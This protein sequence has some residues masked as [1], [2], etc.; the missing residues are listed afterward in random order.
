MTNDFEWDHEVDVLIVGAGAAG[1]AGALAGASKGLD[2][3]LIEKTDRYGGTTA[4]SGGGMWIP[5][6][7]VLERENAGDTV[8]DARTYFDECLALNHDDVPV[9][10][11]QAFL[12][13]GPKAIAF[14]EGCSKHIKFEWVKGYPDYHPELPGGRPLGRQIQASAFDAG[15]LG[16]E[17]ANLRPTLRLVPMPFGMWIMIQEGRH[18]SM[19]GVS[20]RSR[21]LSIRLGLRGLLAKLRGKKIMASGGHMLIA[22]LRAAMI[23]AQI[24]LWL[25]T[26]LEEL[27]T[28]DAGDVVGA[29]VKRDGEP[30]RVRVRG[31][32][33][34]TTGGFERNAEMRAEFQASPIGTKW[35]L[36]AEGST[37]DGHRAGMNVGAALGLMDDS[38]WGPG[39]LLPSGAASFCLNERQVGGGII[40]NSL[41][42][43]FTNESAPYVN[44]VHAMYEGHATGVPHIP[45]WF[46]IHDRFRKRYKLGPLLPRQPIPK[47]WFDSGVAVQAPTL[48][49]LAMK[50]EVPAEGLEATVARFGEFARTG[51]DTDF[52]RGDSAYDRYYADISTKPNPC[53]GAL[54]T[55]PFYAFK[56][57]PSDLGTKGGLVCDEYSRVLRADGSVISGLYAAG[58]ASASVTGHEYPGPGSTIG[59]AVTFAYIAAVHISEQSRSSSADSGSEGVLHRDE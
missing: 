39:I 49:E 29:V 32:L 38:W 41:G 8:D 48:R 26:P 42:E 36:G 33:M 44:V 31:G 23:E 4:L 57:V 20:W 17:L 35:T 2:T 40:V 22:R 21:M 18:L 10:R 45:A 51:V 7:H 37:G 47:E 5:N 3:L 46:V 24:P 27:V 9:A 14:L 53:L 55:P 56:M 12:T 52:R 13:E 15:V 54:D 1:M 30:L 11:R 16:A 58:N 6:S 19:V 43:R 28:N 59:P 25:S 50:M 34:L